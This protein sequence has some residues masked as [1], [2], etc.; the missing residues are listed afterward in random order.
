VALPAPEAPR[1]DAPT[2]RFAIPAGLL[3]RGANAI[4]LTWPGGQTPALRN[5]R[6]EVSVPAGA[7]FSYTPPP[8]HPVLDAMPDHTRLEGYTLPVVEAKLPAGAASGAIEIPI[9]ASTDHSAHLS[10]TFVGI[11]RMWA[12]IDGRQVWSE[13]TDGDGYG[14]LAYHGTLRLDTRRLADG[15]HRILVKAH[16][17]SGSTGFTNGSDLYR[18]DENVRLL[19]RN[20]SQ[21]AGASR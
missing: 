6:I 10:G 11:D 1:L 12:E 3:R 16:L 17:K 15:Y 21:T 13:S 20:A 14:T 19:V 18:Y 8:P 7:P 9:S 2:L 5:V 4:A